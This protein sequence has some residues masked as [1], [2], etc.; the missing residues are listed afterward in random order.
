MLLSLRS[1]AHADIS[2]ICVVLVLMISFPGN[3]AADERLQ[4]HSISTTEHNI[5]DLRASSLS[6]GSNQKLGRSSS[7]TIS[8]L[9][10]N[11]EL[12]HTINF[13]AQNASK[14]MQVSRFFDTTQ[15][16]EDATIHNSEDSNESDESS[17]IRQPVWI[18]VLARNKNSF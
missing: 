14:D 4:Q 9:G 3:K 10:K 13:G 12:N 11:L 17:M 8:A 18:I 16:G 7:E 6:V 1:G 15:E 5:S 2:C